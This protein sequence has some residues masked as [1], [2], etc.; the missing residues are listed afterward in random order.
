MCV[1]GLNGHNPLSPY[2]GQLMVCSHLVQLFISHTHF[3]VTSSHSSSILL[4]PL[5]S[6]I[7]QVL[8][9]GSSNWFY[10]ETG[11]QHLEEWVT[12]PCQTNWLQAALCII[13]RLQKEVN[14]SH[15]LGRVTPS[16]EISWAGF[17]SASCSGLCKGMPMRLFCLA[18][19]PNSSHTSQTP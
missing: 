11:Q 2:Q 4:P 10:G 3:S 16:T 14:N 5:S 12:D 8:S 13:V 17:V 15:C 6:V 18:W 9:Q 1:C 7:I 19:G